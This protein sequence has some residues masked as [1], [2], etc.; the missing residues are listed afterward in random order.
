MTFSQSSFNTFEY[1]N[2]EEKIIHTVILNYLCITVEELFYTVNESIV[3]DIDSTDIGYDIANNWL[4]EHT[5]LGIDGDEIDI[6]KYYNE[7]F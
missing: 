5:F 3:Q 6:V 7:N 4:K 1:L 2:R